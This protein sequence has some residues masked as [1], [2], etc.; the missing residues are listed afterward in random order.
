MTNTEH[1]MVVFEDDS[2]EMIPC[3][4]F[5]D[6]CKQIWGVIA[7]RVEAGKCHQLKWAITAKEFKKIAERKD[8]ILQELGITEE[9]K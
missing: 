4:S 7:Q 5:S 2:I 8:R 6:F 1:Y 9:P 3:K